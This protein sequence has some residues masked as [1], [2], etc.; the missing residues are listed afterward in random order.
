MSLA[1]AQE[2]M[3]RS[4]LMEATKTTELFAR[5]RAHVL[6]Q[7]TSAR[8]DAGYSGRWD[9]GGA[10][11]LESMVEAWWCG[12]QGRIPPEFEKHLKQV[13]KEADPEWQEYQRLQT[14]F[15]DAR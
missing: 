11:R 6:A 12:L 3:V 4:W 15:G 14:K 1:K 5:V 9:D 10:N 7:A 13:T 2:R 8:E